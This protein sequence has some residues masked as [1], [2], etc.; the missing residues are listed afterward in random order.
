MHGAKLTAE[1]AIQN[2]EC[3]FLSFFLARSFPFVSHAGLPGTTMAHADTGEVIASLSFFS[4]A[5][6]L[7]ML[8]RWRVE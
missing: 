2:F 6:F 8:M 5:P 3:Q 4:L 1:G 7:S